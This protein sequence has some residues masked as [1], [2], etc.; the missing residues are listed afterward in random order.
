MSSVHYNGKIT[1][2]I[3]KTIEVNISDNDIFN[4]ITQCNNADTLRY[5]GNYALKMASRIEKPD[6]DDFRSRA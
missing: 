3:T 2:E 6:D 1:V 4:W 5:I